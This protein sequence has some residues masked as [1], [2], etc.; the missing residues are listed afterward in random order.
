MIDVH[1]PYGGY[2]CS[3]FA[4]WQGSLSHL[5]S[6]EF[7]AHLCHEALTEK[8]I[9]FELFD[10][11][12]LGMTIPQQHCF[13]G[14]PWLA[15]LAGLEKIGGPTV[16]QAC[17]TSARVLVQSSQE[18]QNKGAKCVLVVTTDRTSNGPQI[19][20][21][22]PMGM[23]GTGS[24]E[25]WTLDNFSQDPFIGCDMTE[26][27]E[28]CARK[29]KVSTEQQHEVVLRR[30]EQYQDALSNDSAFLKKFMP[31]PFPV[32]DAR[33]K[34]TVKSLDGDEGIFQTT[35]ESLAKLKPVKED[36]T[37]TY[38]SQTFPADGAAGMIVTTKEKAEEISA[39]SAI[40]ITFKSYGQAREAKGFMPAAPIPASKEAL[41]KAGID[42]SDLSAIKSHNPFAV[43]DIIFSLQ[44]GV[45]VMNMNNFGSSLIWG[46]PQG[47]TGMR[48]MIELIEELVLKGGGWG[49]FQGCAAGDTAMAVVLKVDDNR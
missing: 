26:T 40:Q 6:L 11:G 7:A 13:Y 22:N 32:P 44:T 16:S 43:N 42:F 20:Y 24:Y 9:P 18:I 45:D 5:H 39:D 47:P 49:L 3:P 35:E 17:A 30:Y 2:W 4:K 12:I 25:C 15:G 27:G 33:Y 34:K 19:Y 28:N 14:L 41:E 8:D 48:A 21:P 31:L 1:I 29:W 10:A 37:I 36:G 46:H 23:G 38:G